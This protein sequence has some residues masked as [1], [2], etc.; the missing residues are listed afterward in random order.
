VRPDLL[1]NL[2]AETTHAA[3]LAFLV[4]DIPPPAELSVATGYVNV[5]GLHH[6]ASVLEPGRPVRLLLGALP[7]P[8]L[9]ERL[10]A[11]SFETQLGALVGERDFSRF[12]PSRAAERLRAVERWLA[13]G[14]VDVRR[15]VQRFL[16]GKAYLFRDDVD[17][18][19]VLVSSANLTE[20]GLRHNLE[21]GLVDYN[22]GPSRAAHAWYDDLWERSE[23]FGDELRELLFPAVDLVDPETAY[24]R[25][26]VDLYGAD[27]GEATGPPPERV[28]LADFQRD[29]YE[30]ARRIVAD[31]GGVVYADGVGTGK[32][33]IGL[34]FLEEYALRDGA[35]ALV[36]C[37]AQLKENWQRRIATTRLPGTVLSFNELAADEQLVPDAP[38]ARRHLPVDR[39]AYRLVVVDEAHALRNEGTT[40]YRAMERLLGGEPKH[41]VLLTATPINN[42]LW[43]LYNLV[44]LFARHDR[45]FAR[46]GVPS[47][48][49]LFL[50]AGA[51]ERDPENLDPDVLFPLAD[52]VS[53][54]RDRRFIELHYPGAVF[55]DGT[56]VRFPE[57]RLRTRRYDLDAA[58]P[59]LFHDIVDEIAA[60]EMARYRP[61]AWLAEPDEDAAEAQL[62]G[63]LQSA[64]LKRFESSWTSCLATVERMLLAHEAFLGA[65]QEGWV[66]SK[67]AL[68]EAARVEAG[69]TGL[70]VSVVEALEDDP[71]ARVAADFREGYGTAVAGDRD[72][73]ERI[74][75]RLR[76]LSPEQDPKLTLLRE[77]LEESPA[78]KVAVFSS[79]GETVAYLDAQLPARVGGRDR[80][81]VIG[82]EST[83]DERTRALGRFCP[84]TVVRPGYAPPDGEVDLLLSTDVLS[85]GQNLQQAQAVISYD[86]PWN[87]QRV[88]QRNGRVIRL[89][90]P[91]EEVF[92]TT[93]LP[94]PGELEELLR[95]EATVRAKIR[96]AGVYGMDVEVIEGLESELRSYA[97]RL[98][99]G[100]VGLLDEDG[101]EEEGSGAFLGEELRALVLRALEEGE[102]RRVEALPWGIGAV[103]RQTVSGRSRGAPGVFFAIRTPQGQRYW[104][105]AEEG[106]AEVVRSPLE[107]LRRINPEGSGAGDLQE[108]DLEA[109]WARAAADA[110]EE[111]NRRADPRSAQDSIGPAQRWALE[112]LRDPAVIL[113]EGAEEA[114]EALGVERSLA[115]RRALNEARA[116]LTAGRLSPNEAA[117]RIVAV[118][119]NAGLRPVT[120]E[121]LPEPV[122][123]DDLGVVCWIAVLPAQE[124]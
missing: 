62:G 116:E 57:P 10:P 36:I 120:L 19:A 101:E 112:L 24:L 23:P 1:D 94:A 70:A 90:S 97:E 48:R 85:E 71:E 88:V 49:D 74:R 123:V 73:L 55:P 83:P 43:D 124:A 111:H 50:R 114:A 106:T 28:A 91:H 79:Y 39:D 102:L 51:N 117:E 29:G 2:G 46:A 75:E 108:V 77:L 11:L 58:S 16:H 21:L 81:S 7:E 110:V 47:A 54:R 121:D 25:A 5:G 104:R 89:L 59:G 22:P 82:G 18:R 26:L 6:L 56:P 105:Y 30:R 67:G 9:G 76:G 68:R 33:E 60:L 13:S 17:A 35:N 15:F 69:E 115:V 98:T 37:S 4:G 53:V 80:L 42:G 31:H 34:A 92:L 66:P 65:W 32:T 3:A 38:H 14:D 96:A 52:A 61:G 107:C 64:L 86:M 118:V 8:G 72:R 119:R 93:M 78:Q 109:A 63:L 40:W 95:L 20:A 12:P 27:L 103:L 87:P 44:M 122:E 84:E 41:V 113:P 99:E 45:A 100:D